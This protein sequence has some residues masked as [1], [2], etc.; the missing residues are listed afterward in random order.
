[1]ELEGRTVVV[2]GGGSGLGAHLVR[3]FALR[4][5]HVVIADRDGAEADRLAVDL[6]QRGSTVTSCRCD[7]T[8]EADLHALLAVADDLG[9]VDVL[10]NNAGGW[11]DGPLQYPDAPHEDWDHVLD[12]NLRAPMRLLQLCLAGMRGR[13]RG[14]VVNVASS[15]GVETSAYDSPPYAVAKAGLVRLTTALAGLEEDGIRVTCV[16]PGWVGL[17]RAHT[18]RAAMD[19]AELQTLPALVPPELIAD[20]VVRL[21]RDDADAGTVLELLDGLTRRVLPGAT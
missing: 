11:G 20:E 17:P 5:A 3:A 16:V 19:P 4:G 1:M 14:A 12:L 6:R 18:Q 7:V 15:A 9:G 10:V 8:A 13:G 2:T 21:V